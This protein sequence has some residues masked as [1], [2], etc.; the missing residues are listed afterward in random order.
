MDYSKFYTPIEIASVL[1]NQLDIAPPESVIDICC[2]GGNLLMAAHMRWKKANLIGVDIK[3]QYLER[4]KCVLSDGRKFALTH[5]NKYSLVLANPPFD[6]VSPYLEFPELY[7]EMDKNYI[8][9]RLEVE[10]LFANLK[11]LDDDGTLLIIMPSSFVTSERFSKYRKYIARRYH[12]KYIISLPLETFG[13]SNI[14]TYALIIKN[15]SPEK[16]RTYR[17]D[18]ILSRNEGYQL[19]AKNLHSRNLVKIGDWEREYTGKRPLANLDFRRGNISSNHFSKDGAV[20]LHTAKKMDGWK[21][22]IRYTIA[23][24]EKAVFADEG[25]IIISRVGKSAGSWTIHEGGKVPISDCLFRIKDPYGNIARKLNSKEYCR[26]L[27]GV[28]TRYITIRD[29]TAWYSELDNEK[30]F[31]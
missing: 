19:T 16:R 13:S 27:K 5:S 1:I 7:E 6:Y 17:C 30:E 10:M 25:D 9:S 11:L 4:V 20:V 22:S 28:A 21:P 26:P 14:N 3:Q 24:L 23:S 31:S 15:C 8:T 12:L 18:I 29:F 2:G